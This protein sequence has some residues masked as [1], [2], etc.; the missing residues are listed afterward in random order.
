MKYT[1]FFCA[2]FA[3]SLAACGNRGTSG[4]T[5]PTPPDRYGYRI[6]NSYPH[7]TGAYTQGL[8]WHEGRLYESTGEIGRSTLR[9]VDLATGE[10]TRLTKLPD[11]VFGEGST[12]LGGK[13]YQLTWTEGRAFTYDPATFERTGEFAYRGEGWGLATDGEKLY[14][15][16]G[17]PN[18]TVRNPDTFV[19][20]STIVVRREGV[21][22]PYIN[23]LEWID[24]K[25]WANV[26]MTNE[27]VIINPADGRVEGSIDF[28]GL[29]SQIII[30][31]Y[32]TDV[33]NGIAIDHATGRIF[34]TGK[35]WNRM[36]E[37]EIFKK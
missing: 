21:A 3:V 23:E 5:E 32:E 37:I 30:I 16:D 4:Q 33:L 34:V 6:V 15:S 11:N 19:A 8:F 25:L 18:I 2:M 36:F 12:L 28:T 9:E 26:Y 24:G 1:L 31:P 13:I 20:E 35:R 22:V 29:L 14:M 7:D 10:P 27:I 17:T